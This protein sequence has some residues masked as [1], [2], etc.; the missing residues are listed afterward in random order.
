MT[1]KQIEKI[2]SLQQRLRKI[3]KQQRL[4]IR[5][6]LFWYYEYDT[7]LQKQFPRNFEKELF[8]AQLRLKQIK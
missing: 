1:K 2:K 8:K 4:Y 7:L 5:Q 6:A 3:R